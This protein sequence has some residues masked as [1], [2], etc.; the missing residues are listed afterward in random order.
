MTN[1]LPT[2]AVTLST[3]IPERTVAGPEYGRRIAMSAWS[4][5]Y[6]RPAGSG[7]PF[8]VARLTPA[9]DELDGDDA[10]IVDDDCRG[11]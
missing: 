7:L 3:G 5:Y 8:A 9:D 4:G 11:A 6:I 1:D 10:A 2:E